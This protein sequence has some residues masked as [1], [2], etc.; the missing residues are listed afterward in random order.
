MTN[1]FTNIFGLTRKEEYEYYYIWLNKK[2]VNTNTNIFWLTNK[3]EYKY[4]YS[5]WY[6][7][8]RIHHTCFGDFMVVLL[9]SCISFHPC[10]WLL[11]VVC[12]LL[13]WVCGRHLAINYWL[14]RSGDGIGEGK[15]IKKWRQNPEAEYYI[16]SRIKDAIF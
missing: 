2:G 7:L 11:S 14:A 12:C 6:F 15:E 1:T 9:R 5:D 3:G 8:I 10:Y 13:D 16:F 4:K